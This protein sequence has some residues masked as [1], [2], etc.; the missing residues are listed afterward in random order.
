MKPQNHKIELRKPG[1]G[2]EKKQDANRPKPHESRL[3]SIHSVKLDGETVTTTK[4][5]GVTVDT[6]A[7]SKLPSINRPQSTTTR[8]F[9]PKIGCFEVHYI[10]WDKGASRRHLIF[11]K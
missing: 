1:G 6:K 9:L 8:P 7:P 4:K 11:S 3:K 5:E 10:Y 2:G